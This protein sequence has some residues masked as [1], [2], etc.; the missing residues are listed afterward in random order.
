M[1]IVSV[2][3]RRKGLTEVFTDEIESVMISTKIWQESG[4]REENEISFEEL[5]EM[6]KKSDRYRAKEKALYLLTYRDHSKKELCEKINKTLP[7]DSAKAAADYMEE[8]GLLDDERYAKNYAESLLNHKGFGKRRIF[9][10]LE[11]KGVDRD[12]IEQIISELCFSPE[13]KIT[14]I[15]EKKYP[16]AIDDEKVYNRAVNA[17]IRY[18]YQYSEINA[19]FQKLQNKD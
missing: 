16:Q 18:G 19:A 1:I 14:E 5:D 17:L 9:H 2:K 8:I 6:I 7:K 4:Y 13:E 12:T 15:I 3:L 11:A 10:E